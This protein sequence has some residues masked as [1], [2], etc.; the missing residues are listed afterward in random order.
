MA[1]SGEI[2]GEIRGPQSEEDPP[3]FKMVPP[4]SRDKSEC[5]HH[6]YWLDEKWRIVRCRDCDEPVDPFAILMRRAEWEASWEQRARCFEDTRR[7]MLIEAARRL[8]RLRDTHHVEAHE[9]K[10]AIERTGYYPY[11]G[12][13]GITT[14]DLAVIVRKIEGE[15]EE[16]RFK[17][18]QV[19]RDK[20]NQY[21]LDARRQS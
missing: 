17:K 5:E 3:T 21:N 18:R 2:I 6:R 4:Y 13:W 7:R 20:R 8:T 10:S 9:L 12:Q 15:V 1:D 14:D 19:K 16:R 11:D